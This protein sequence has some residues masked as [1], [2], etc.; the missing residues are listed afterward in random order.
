MSSTYSSYTYVHKRKNGMFKYPLEIKQTILNDSYYFFSIPRKLSYAIQNYPARKSFY[1]EDW[2]DIKI[3]ANQVIRELNDESASING[4]I[5]WNEFSI[6][7]KGD[8]YEISRKMSQ[9]LYWK[10]Y[11]INK[12]E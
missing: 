10:T 1:F 7:Y 6:N 2:D 9:D 12:I 11:E 4:K 3:I 8:I 5:Y